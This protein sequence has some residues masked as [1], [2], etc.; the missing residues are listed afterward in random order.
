MAARPSFYTRH[1]VASIFKHSK[2]SCRLLRWASLP[3]RL[4]AWQTST[5]HQSNGRRTM[6]ST[7]RR[8]IHCQWSSHACSTTGVGCMEEAAALGEAFNKPGPVTLRAN[9]AVQSRDA[10]LKSLSSEGIECQEGTLSP[11]A[12]HLNAAGGRSEWGGSV[13]N[14]NG[15]RDG[16]FEVQDE[17]S[18]FIVL[19]CEVKQGERVLD[20]CAGNG[21]KALALAALVGEGGAVLAHDVVEADWRLYAH[22]PCVRALMA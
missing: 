11:W 2:P 19:A 14:L 5:L 18:Q 17:G 21:G 22:R 13:W 6:W 9:L 20:L 12:V 7:W 1:L 10:L 16:A 3:R 4:I 8:A 15:W